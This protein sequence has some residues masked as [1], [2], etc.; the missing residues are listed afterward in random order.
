[1]NQEEKF[2]LLYKIFSP[3]APIDNLDFFAGRDEKL[4]EIRETI[5]EKGQHAIIFGK[6]GVGKT[7][8]SNILNQVFESFY[9]VKVTCNRTDNFAS[10]WEKAF[11]KVQFTETTQNVGFKKEVISE[12][13]SI[14]LPEGVFIDASVVQTALESTE[15]SFV[16]IFDEF[17]SI[18]DEKT[19]IM[20]ADTIK[21]LSDNISNITILIVGIASNILELLGKH[22]SLERCVRQ[23][24][25][26]EMS[27]EES[28]DL[29]YSGL[30]ILEIKIEE[31]I[32]E[33]I[34]EYA[35]GFPHYLHLLTKFAAEEA[36]LENVETINRLHFD[37]AVFKSIEH[38]DFSLRTA[39]KTAVKSSN[40][41]NQFEDIIYA[42]AITDTDE[43]DCCFPNEVLNVFNSIRNSNINVESIYYNLGMLCKP[44]RGHVL[45]KTGSS[46]NFKY[47]FKNPLMKAYVKLKMHEKL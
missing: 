21:A 9:F 30:Q 32:S 36:I 43:D 4:H 44:E 24:F 5:I 22:P 8:I 40:S 17:D 34:I 46:K 18:E 7:S 26:P 47:R 19:K 25:I 45:E 6:R 12:T 39:F 20:V 38:T 29:I 3:A 42:C 41:K 2:S 35:S 33:K 15:T 27:F 14:S 28:S 13:V 11:K 1:M 16:F 37:K 23:I 31:D 10:I